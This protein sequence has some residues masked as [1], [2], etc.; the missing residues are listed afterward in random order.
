MAIT[1]VTPDS[2][3]FLRQFPGQNEVNLD[4]VDEYAGPCLTTHPLTAFTPNLSA[5]VTAPTLGVGGTNLGYMY[6]I[7]DQLYMWGQFRFGSSGIN[8]GSGL[9]LL[10]L[11]FQV[12]S[13]LGAST[14]M[15]ENPVIG[16]GTVHDN[17]S[18]AGRM[19][20]TVHLRTT[21]QL[22]FGIRMNAGSVNRDLRSAGYI[23]WDVLDGV[24]WCARVQRAI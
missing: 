2:S 3:N 9:Y 10:N 12:N 15:G 7:F 1:L 18:N 24:S 11:P 4:R 6:R 22:V 23:T 14:T 5:D 8:A 16:T 19:P 21:S 13:V 20:L 17:S